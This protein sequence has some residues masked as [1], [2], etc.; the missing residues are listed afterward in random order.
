MIKPSKPASPV[1]ENLDN[2]IKWNDESAKQWDA[3]PRVSWAKY[4]ED[5]EYHK[6]TTIHLLLLKKML[7]DEEIRNLLIEKN[8]IEVI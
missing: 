4:S 6:G 7:N 8:L 2:Q 1:F 5:A 3:I